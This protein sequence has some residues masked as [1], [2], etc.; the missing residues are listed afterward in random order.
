MKPI[1]VAKL[2]KFQSWTSFDDNIGKLISLA[3][4]E[5]ENE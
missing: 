4:L 3:A 2:E 5:A 1:I